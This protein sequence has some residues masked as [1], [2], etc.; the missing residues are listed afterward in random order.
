MSYLKILTKKFIG[1]LTEEL[2][3]IKNEK[4]NLPY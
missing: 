4:D 3:N 1:F 2:K